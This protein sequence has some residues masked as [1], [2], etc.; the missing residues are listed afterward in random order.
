AS[1][2][3]GLAYLVF[4]G[5]RT[6]YLGHFLAGLGATLLL[7]CALVKVRKKR[8]GWDGVVLGL[9]AVGAGFVTESSIF[10]F[11]FFDPVDFCNQ[12]LGAVMACACVVDERL[13]SGLLVQLSAAG[14]VLLIGGFVF[15]FA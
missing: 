12:S 9:V 2:A 13:P 10:R 3:L 14:G 15:A 8:V 6:D 7:T 4:L 1:V 11:A 5:H